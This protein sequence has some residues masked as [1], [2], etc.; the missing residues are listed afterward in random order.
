MKRFTASY[1]VPGTVEEV[2]QL[3]TT[4]HYVDEKYRSLGAQELRITV[5]EDGDEKF[6]SQVE[7]IVNMR[8]KAPG[9]AKKFVKE[10]MTVVHE[11]WWYKQGETKEG[12]FKAALPGVS[13][14]V[15]AALFLEQTPS[16]GAQL[17]IDAAV[18]VNIPL[19]GGKLE[20]F[21]VNTAEEKFE[22]DVNATRAYLEKH[23]Q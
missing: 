11:I 8:D 22:D 9:F 4:E 2:I 21:M 1:E 16:G 7:R 6:H 13:G 20:G 23:L 10:E 3:L 5:L 17:R 14:G 18:T 19:V 15:E 12:G